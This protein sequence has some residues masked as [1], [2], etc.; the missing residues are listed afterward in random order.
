M[1]GDVGGRNVVKRKRGGRGERK[2]GGN[3]ERGRKTCK[4][5]RRLARVRS[6]VGKR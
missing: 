1:G 5:E 2:G 6:V 4:V 3:R